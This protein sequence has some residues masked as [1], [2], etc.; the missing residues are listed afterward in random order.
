MISGLVVS[1]SLFCVVGGE[2]NLSAYAE[3]E[4]IERTS[5]EYSLGPIYQ[6]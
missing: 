6:S 2:T 3:I 1:S 5:P 4:V